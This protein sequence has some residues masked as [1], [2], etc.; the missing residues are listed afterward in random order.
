MSERTMK[1]KSKKNIL[2]IIGVVLLVIGSGPLLIIMGLAAL[3]FGDDPNPNPVIFGIM[4]GLTFWPSIIL[5]VIGLYRNYK[6]S[7]SRKV[8][9]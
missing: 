9:V 3:G 5:I 1:T 8:S 2:L 6:K 4:A 7:T